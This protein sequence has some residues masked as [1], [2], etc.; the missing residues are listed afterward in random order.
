M[1]DVKIHS[2]LVVES[3]IV[4]PIDYS[5]AIDLYGYWYI[6]MFIA[7]L[8]KLLSKRVSLHSVLLH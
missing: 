8:S 2:L 3:L 5:R 4:K 6:A 1:A 7:A